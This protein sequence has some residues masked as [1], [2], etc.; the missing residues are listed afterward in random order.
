MFPCTDTFAGHAENA[1]RFKHCGLTSNCKTHF[2]DLNF[3]YQKITDQQ[4][5]RIWTLLTCSS[6][7][8]LS[9]NHFFPFLYESVFALDTLLMSILFSALEH[10][11]G[12]N[13]SLDY[14]RGTVGY[15]YYCRDEQTLNVVQNLSINTFQLQVQPFAVKGD[16][17][18]AG[19]HF[20]LVECDQNTSSPPCPFSRVLFCLISWGMP[21]GWR[22]HVDPHCSRSSFSGARCHRALGLPHWEEEE[23]CWLPEHLRSLLTHMLSEAW[24]RPYPTWK[25]TTVFRDLKLAPLPLH[26]SLPASVCLC[27]SLPS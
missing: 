23:P 10:I 6:F 16:Q 1:G 3:I 9:H 13:S 21:A 22:W 5:H 4:T 19:K 12:H 20:R 11:S 25:L 27:C 17:F 2:I 15:S 26:V 18:G 8:F 7:K 14:L 24:T